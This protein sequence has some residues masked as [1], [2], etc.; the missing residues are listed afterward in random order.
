MRDSLLTDDAIALALSGGDDYELLFTI[1]EDKKVGM[2]TSMS[3]AGTQVTCIGQINAS[4][5]I[6]AT[7]NNK[8]TPIDIA[9]FEHFSE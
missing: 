6:S 3:N 4:Q 7:L 2:E 9:G 1:S 8:P 5:T